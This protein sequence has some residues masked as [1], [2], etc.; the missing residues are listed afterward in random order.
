MGHVAHRHR[1][2]RELTVGLDK[3]P[4]MLAA[5]AEKQADKW[6]DQGVESLRSKIVPKLP[7]ETAGIAYAVADVLNTDKATLHE[8]TH[9]GF[10]AI[11]SYLALGNEDDAYLIF[12]AERATFEE[13]QNALLGAMRASV[14]AKVSRDE[15]WA[16]V[17]KLAIEVLQVAG[18]MAIPLLLAML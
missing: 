16:K 10:T 3:L 9:G 5:R 15:M 18:K 7:A 17:K 14:G 1:E 11:A 2:A 12:L 4:A 8:I 13:R 6:V